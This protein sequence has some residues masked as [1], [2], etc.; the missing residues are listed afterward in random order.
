MSCSLGTARAPRAF[1][2]VVAGA[3]A[4]LLVI[5]LSGCFSPHPDITGSWSAPGKD[6]ESI[7]YT[8][9]F[10][11]DGTSSVETSST[12]SGST[13]Y[14]E[15]ATWATDFGTIVMDFSEGEDLMFT[16][17]LGGDSISDPYGNTYHRI[18]E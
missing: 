5:V 10:N 13:I 17:S 11:S 8:Y 18:T 12:D 2:R 14:Y 7:T 6:D 4:C 1:A 9:T 16:L 3:A 15:E